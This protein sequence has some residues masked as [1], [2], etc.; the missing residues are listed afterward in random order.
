MSTSESDSI[1]ARKILVSGA[2]GYIGSRLVGQLL[3]HNPD[4]RV[5]IRDKRKILD[6]TWKDRVEIFLADAKDY[7]DTKKALEGVHTAFY[8]LHS[9]KVGSNFEILEAA[10]AKNFA[11]AAE[12]VGVK[13]IVYLGGIANDV[14]LSKHMLSRVNTG[15][16]LNAGSV[17]VLQIRA[18]IIIGSGSASFEM[19]RQLTHELPFITTPRWTKNRTEPISIRDVLHYLTYTA[20]LKQPVSG[21]FDIG[22]PDVLTYSDLIQRFAKLSGLPRRWIIKV[23]FPSPAVAAL[24]IGIFTRIPTALARPLVGSLISEVV[25]DPKKSFNGLIEPPHKGLLSLDDSIKLALSKS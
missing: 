8:L 15:R 12:D 9:L 25:A 5:M 11:K 21:V 23:P 6:F 20:E 18:G 13:Q 17:L 19:L 3:L 14:H 24:L 10:N 1:L 4:I 7:E 22:G 16:L 2:S